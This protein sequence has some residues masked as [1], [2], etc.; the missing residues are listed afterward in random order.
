MD[1]L[2]LRK[3]A[4]FFRIGRIQMK[5]KFA[6]G[7]PITGDLSQVKAYAAQEHEGP[8]ASQETSLSASRRL[9][10]RSGPEIRLG[11]AQRLK[12]GGYCDAPNSLFRSF[13]QT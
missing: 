2:S 6:A 7:F 4:G 9:R 8:A 5:W 11:R 13:D 1:A 3:L 12:E 10:P